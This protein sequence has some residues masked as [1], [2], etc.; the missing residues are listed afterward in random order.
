M[1][2]GPWEYSRYNFS[3][4]KKGWKCAGPST[5]DF[6]F[7]Y[8]SIFLAKRELSWRMD[9]CL[10]AG[11][12]EVVPHWPNHRGSSFERRHL[13]TCLGSGVAISDIIDFPSQGSL[14]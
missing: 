9:L 4:R 12:V 7:N 8:S 13:R 3:R 6:D 5:T 2:Y 11:P 10:W 1:E 14:L